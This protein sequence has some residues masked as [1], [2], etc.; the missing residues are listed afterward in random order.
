MQNVIHEGEQ[1][2]NHLRTRKIRQGDFAT[3]MGM[4]RQNLNKYFQKETL[5][6]KFKK[7]LAAHGVTIF[8]DVTQTANRN[9][10]SIITQQVGQM[11]TAD[12]KELE[13]QHLKEKVALLEEINTLLKS[14]LKE[15]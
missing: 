2:R 3:A 8:T 11:S 6:D 10:K 9:V 15:D 5:E 4:T 12:Q 7:Q 13:L 14:K 1:L